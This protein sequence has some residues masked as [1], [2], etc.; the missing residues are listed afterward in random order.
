MGREVFTS[1]VFL[2]FCCLWSHIRKTI[3]MEIMVVITP[4]AL[5]RWTDD[6]WNTLGNCSPKSWMEAGEEAQDASGLVPKGG[7]RACATLYEP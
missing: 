4:S 2:G 3:K 5:V 6:S 7:I 1:E